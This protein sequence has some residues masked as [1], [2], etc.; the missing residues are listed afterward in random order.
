M[1]NISIIVLFEHFLWKSDEIPLDN[2][3]ICMIV[4]SKG[5]YMSAT[6]RDNTKVEVDIPES[7]TNTVQSL[8]LSHYIGA[9]YSTLEKS[10]VGHS[11][12][13]K[14]QSGHAELANHN[15]LANIEEHDVMNGSN[16][17]SILGM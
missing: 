7:L 1:F 14:L 5:N 9:Q 11:Q 10:A 17:S 16:S 4:F 2:F 12:K 15:Y 6:R 13:H 3:D 8:K